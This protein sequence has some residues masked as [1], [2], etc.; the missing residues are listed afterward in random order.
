MPPNS[1][2]KQQR[3]HRL[4]HMLDHT[5]TVLFAEWA[6]LRG[7]TKVRRITRDCGWALESLANGDLITAERTRQHVAGMVEQLPNGDTTPGAG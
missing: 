6:D 2:T 5:L 7:Q 1:L 4:A 3:V